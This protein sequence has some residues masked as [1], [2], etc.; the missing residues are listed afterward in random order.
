MTK[1]NEQRRA[2]TVT[3]SI[4]LATCI[5]VLLS[6]ASA[7]NSVPQDMRGFWSGFIQEGINPPE[8]VRTEITSQVNRRFTGLVQPPDPVQPIAIEGTVS[9]SGKVNYQGESADGHAIGKTDLL[10]FG[11]GAAILN[12]SLTRFRPDRTFIIP[13][14]L[15]LRPFEAD[16]SEPVQPAG[17]Y[18][19]NLN[20]DGT[21]GEIVFVL[22]NPPDPVRPTSFGGNVGVTIG[23]QTRTFALIG[24]MNGDGRFIAIGHLAGA[25]HMTLN[26]N[27]GQPP[28]PVQPTTLIGNFT[29][30]FG[31]GSE[32]EGTFQTELTRTNP[33]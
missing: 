12:G 29:I 32:L 25:G 15:V 24:T 13:C 4:G 14:V 28:D 19:G 30:E 18:L 6:T 31:D 2:F 27:L 26:G 1:G 20:G 9:A 7:T 33:S 16:P 5:V 11:G 23:G 8:P 10:D 21:T 3:A 17:R 22:S